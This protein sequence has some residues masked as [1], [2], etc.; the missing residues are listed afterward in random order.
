MNSEHFVNTSNRTQ[1]ERPT[2]QQSISVRSSAK[3]LLQTAVQRG[4][5]SRAGRAA[6][7]NEMLHAGEAAFQLRRRHRLRLP[8]PG[9]VAEHPGLAHPLRKGHRT[10]V[11]S[12]RYGL[13]MRQH[14]PVHIIGMDEV[15]RRE[16]QAYLRVVY[17]TPD[18]ACITG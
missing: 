16:S 13:R 15:S 5:T 8:S 18:S 6:G 3:A 1:P 10:G 7:V 17:V 14:P 4:R 11:F 9:T 2:S 12:N